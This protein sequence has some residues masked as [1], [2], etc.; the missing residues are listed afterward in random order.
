MPLKKPGQGE[1]LYKV[2]YAGY[3]VV[4]FLLS[5]K[6]N[7]VVAASTSLTRTSVVASTNL[8]CPMYS[9]TSRREKSLPLA[10]ASAGSKSVTRLLYASLSPAHIQVLETHAKLFQGYT[11]GGSFAEYVVSKAQKTA[12]IPD[13]LSTKDAASAIVQGLSALTFVREA[14]KVC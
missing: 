2:E 10:K 4:N 6:L 8:R 11:A 5:T 3:I 9:V 12:Q 7:I 13:G 1:V 14:H